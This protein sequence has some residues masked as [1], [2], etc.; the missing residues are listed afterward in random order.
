MQE[1]ADKGARL[2]HEVL[3]FKV[4]VLQRYGRREEFIH[5]QQV[6]ES[7]LDAIYQKLETL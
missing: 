5:Y 1:A 4:E 2:E 3:E 7:R 6:V